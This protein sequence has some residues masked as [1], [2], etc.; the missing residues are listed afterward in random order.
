MRADLIF[1]MDYL[2]EAELLARYPQAAAK[3]F[4]LGAYRRCHWR[5]AEIDDPYRGNQEDIRHCYDCL[6][7]CV[8][9]LARRLQSSV[10][11]AEEQVLD[12][13]SVAF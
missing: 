1:V 5:Q 8:D 6:E 2:N 12:A 3:V 11:S 9:E 4:L 13:H 7:V 10:G